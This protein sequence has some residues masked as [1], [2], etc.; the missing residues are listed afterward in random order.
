MKNNGIYIALIALCFYYFV[1]CKED[2]GNDIIDYYPVEFEIQVLDSESK[3]VLEPSTKD[4][5]LDKELYI[6]IGD[7]KFNVNYGRPDEP[8]FPY[9]N[10]TRAYMPSWYGAFIAPYWYQYPDMPDRANRLY[11][12]EF[13]GDFLGRIDFILVLDSHTY[14]IGYENKKINGLSVDRHF[15]LDGKELESN[16]FTIRL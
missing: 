11:I 14:H 2:P 7:E 6:I 4:N 1:S 9:P 10:L 8:Y 12:G 13:P 3:N 5:I 16:I 15:Y